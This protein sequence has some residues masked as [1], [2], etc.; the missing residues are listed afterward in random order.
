MKL[1]YGL[2][3]E[4]HHK[5]GDKLMMKDHLKLEDDRELNVKHDRN[6]KFVDECKLKVH[7]KSE[8]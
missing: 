4:P 8:G 6:L 7:D 3:N 1:E 5:V 2:T